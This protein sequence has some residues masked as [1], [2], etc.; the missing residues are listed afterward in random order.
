MMANSDNRHHTA[1]GWAP[2]RSSN[3]LV[4]SLRDFATQ[5]EALPASSKGRHS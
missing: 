5:S 2:S 3:D 1:G 4:C